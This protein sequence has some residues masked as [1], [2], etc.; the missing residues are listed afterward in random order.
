M[1]R[2][3]NNAEPKKKPTLDLRV[4]RNGLA[5]PKFEIIRPEIH[6]CN[7]ELRARSEGQASSV[8]LKHFNALPGLGR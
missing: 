5:K 4:I 8:A 3:R 7:D 2:A 1:L 6:D